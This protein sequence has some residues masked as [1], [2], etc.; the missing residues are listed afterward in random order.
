MNSNI[1]ISGLIIAV[2]AVVGCAD[3][4]SSQSSPTYSSYPAANVQMPSYG[5]IDS[6]QVER[7][8]PSSSGMG[9]VMGGV[10]G[11]VLGNQVGGGSGRAAATAAG[12][13]GGAIVGDRME[14]SRQDQGHDIYKIGV[15]LDNGGYYTVTQ[16]S[17]SDLRV[18]D[19]IRID[20][21]RVYRN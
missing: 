18:G 19:R 11:G 9:A 3:T 6:I 8:Q 12:V 7:S 20:N 2:A 1:K 21:N 16:D 17:I 10:V 14:K 4:N 15:R 13:V 5:R